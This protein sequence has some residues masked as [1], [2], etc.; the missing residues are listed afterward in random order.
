MTD[1]NQGMDQRGYSSIMNVTEAS[2]FEVTNQ[3]AEKKRLPAEGAVTF[4]VTRSPSFRS[5][6]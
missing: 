5:L 2:D 3:P 4:T 1:R 6:K